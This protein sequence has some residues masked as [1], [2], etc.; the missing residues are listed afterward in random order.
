MQS[1]DVSFSQ[2]SDPKK[3]HMS[4]VW[5]ESFLNNEKNEKGEE[6]SN[7]D[8]FQTKHVKWGKYEMTRG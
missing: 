5:G 3:C 1:L 2:Y 8:S 6:M 4:Y 7:F